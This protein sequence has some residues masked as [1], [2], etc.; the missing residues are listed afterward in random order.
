MRLE[1]CLFTSS[2]LKNNVTCPVNTKPNK[3]DLRVGFAEISPNGR[4]IGMNDAAYSVF[5]D[6]FPSDFFTLPYSK[7]HVTCP[8]NTKPH[9]RI[10]HNSAFSIQ[11]SAFSIQHSAFNIQHSAFSIQ[12]LAFCR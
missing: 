3:S 2:V 10:F 1:L 12:P 4:D 11:H 9:K 5:P 8:I 6:K 7:N